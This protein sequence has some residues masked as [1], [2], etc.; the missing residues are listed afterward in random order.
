MKAIGFQTKTVGFF[1]ANI[2]SKATA[3][4]VNTVLS[5]VPNPNM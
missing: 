5:K 1:M 3:G 2:K 4:M